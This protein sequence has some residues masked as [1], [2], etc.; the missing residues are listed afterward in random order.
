VLDRQQSFEEAISTL[1]D[2]LKRYEADAASMRARFLLADSYRRSALALRDEAA[3]VTFAGELQQIRA[4]ARSRLERAATLYRQLI[5][6]FEDRDPTRLTAI[7]KLYLRHA[8][9][10]EADCY[11]ET[12][13]YQAALKLYEDAAGAF[14]DTTSSLAAYVQIINCDVFLGRPNEAQAALARA[15]ILVDAMPQ[16]S[17]DESLSPEKREDWRRYFQWLGE[18]EL[19]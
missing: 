16:S 2:A 12:L 6:E 19:F 18:S 7:E 14:Q 13:D 4:E 11:F 15:L 5:D 9:L 10:Y 3:D 17:Y 1:E 8:Y